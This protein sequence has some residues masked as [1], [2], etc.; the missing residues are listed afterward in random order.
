MDKASDTLLTLWLALVLA[1]PV[2]AYLDP[3]AGSMLLQVILGGSAA[4]FVMVR[5]F[6]RRILVLFGLGKKDEECSASQAS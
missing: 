1:T 5:L 6:W 4:V 3:G 2:H